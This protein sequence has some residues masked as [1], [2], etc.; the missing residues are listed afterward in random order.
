LGGFKSPFKKG[1][2]NQQYNKH[3]DESETSS[4]DSI[5][6][7]DR[8]RTGNL[9]GKKDRLSDRSNDSTGYITRKTSNG[10]NS[11]G[12]TAGLGPPLP[13]SLDRPIDTN[14]LMTDIQNSLAVQNSNDIKKS[15]SLNSGEFSAHLSSNPHTASIVNGEIFQYGGGSD[16]SS[17]GMTTTSRPPQIQVDFIQKMIDEAMEENR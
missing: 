2:K 3:S 13:Y 5:S 12:Q 9:R 10:L 14:Q 6:L 1:K 11:G 16:A 17:V 4:I 15:P 8:E 7:E